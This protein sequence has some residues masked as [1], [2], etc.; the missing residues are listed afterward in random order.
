[1]AAQQ[2]PT[3]NKAIWTAKDNQIMS[4]IVNSVEPHLILSLRPHK[5]AKAMWDFLKLVYNQDNNARRFQLELTIAN[6]TQGDLSV[7]DYY[8]GFL[9]LWSDYSNLVTAMVSGEGLVA[10][11]DVHKTSQRDQ[12]LMKLRPEFESLCASLVNRVP[13]PSLEACFGEF[14]REEQR[15]NTQNTM[16]HA[17]VTSNTVSVAYTAHSL[18]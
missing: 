9:N 1:M 3:L 7:Q 5:S 10:V 15:L 17:R 16:E 8:S 18:C 11:L 12:F 2:L 13:V 6:Y 14:L 4:W